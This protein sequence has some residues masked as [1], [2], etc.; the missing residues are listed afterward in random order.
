MIKTGPGTRNLVEV[1]AA[2]RLAVGRTARRMRQE[3]DGRNLTQMGILFT[4]DH[5]GPMTLGE[6][7]SAERVAPPTITKAVA[8]LEADGLLRKEI[9]EDDRRIQWA[10]LTAAGRQEVDQVRSRRE[11]WL[12]TRLAELDPRDVERLAEV[13]PLLEQ[14]A[15][16][17]E[18]A[19]GGPR[20]G[21]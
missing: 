7:A 2:L 17:E 19:P 13:V 3:A 4:L 21:R 18:V 1:A 15:A 12:A 9:D 16:D 20:A 8:N 11:A 6:L 5:R 10:R 14:I